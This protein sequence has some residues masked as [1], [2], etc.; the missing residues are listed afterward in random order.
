M[1]R[2]IWWCSNCGYES[3]NGGRCHEC[4]EPL[5]SSPLLELEP[6][7]GRDELGYNV[8]RWESESRARLIE[9]L[10]LK[11]IRH[12][13]D[14]DELVVL[15]TDGDQAGDAVSEALGQLP[16]LAPGQDNQELSYNLAGWDDESRVRLLDALV[17]RGTRHRFEGDELV[18]LAA[19]E[20]QGDAAVA[21]A[22][23]RP[24]QRRRKDTLAP[25]GGIS[26]E[27]LE[28]TA[29][30]MSS[31]A[32]ASCSSVKPGRF[33]PDRPALPGGCNATGPAEDWSVRLPIG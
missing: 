10:V 6:G 33:S 2:K 8:E 30:H 4:G 27:I 1:A 15:A 25:D 9:L 19:D 22:L 18:V 17:L 16:E 12:R 29:L 32:R 23:G 14:N 31:G 21:E 3:N 26:Q 5:L 11:R 24:P 13:F 20:R 7:H 28:P